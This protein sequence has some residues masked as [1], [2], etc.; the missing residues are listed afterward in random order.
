MCG[1]GLWG[2]LLI[3]ALLAVL[4]LG[5]AWLFRSLRQTD[6][7]FAVSGGGD[8]ARDMLRRRYAAG[9]I[10]EEEFERRL[11]ALTWR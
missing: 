10:D 7:D 11:S 3:I 9:E 5:G 1:V 6:S 8:P 4:V 2:V